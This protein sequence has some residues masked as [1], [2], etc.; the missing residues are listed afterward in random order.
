MAVKSKKDYSILIVSSSEQ[1][2]TISKKALP[3]GRF[4]VTE[5]RKSASMA[6]RE[7]L[8]RHYDIVLINAPLPDELG[9]DFAMDVFNRYSCGIIIAIP[10]EICDSV[11]ERLIDYGI[12]TVAKPSRSI[13]LSRAIRLLL[14]M[15]E[16]ISSAEKKITKLEDKMEELR[17]VSRAKLVLVEKKGMTEEDAQKYIL[18]QAMD[19]GIT[20]R[21]VAE[22]ILDN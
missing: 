16:R 21:A 4:A 22:D 6:K 3:P 9:V 8:E 17:I 15:Q 20:K 2:N 12:I 7:L 1:F 11:T 19:R 10:G 5:I 18:K 14:A 13:A